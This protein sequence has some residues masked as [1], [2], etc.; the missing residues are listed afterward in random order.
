[1]GYWTIEEVADAL[2]MTVAQVYESR[3]RK[4]YPGNL[5][6]PRGRRLMFNADLVQAG[7][8]EPESTTDPLEAILWTVTGIEEKLARL[9]QLLTPLVSPT[10]T[11]GSP[12]TYTEEE[13]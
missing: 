7:P 10:Y 13:E 5:G 2:G 12:T 11:I 4:E 8:T 3:R 6:K 1:M 9:I